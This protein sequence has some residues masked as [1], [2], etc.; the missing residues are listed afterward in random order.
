YMVGEHGGAAFV[1]I[2]IL[3]TLLI[4]LPIF[5]A[6]VMIGRRSHTNARDA[7]ARLSRHHPF[8]KAA[9]YLTI[10][11][12]V[13]IDCYYSVIG[14]W[15]LDYFLK[16]C[17]MTFVNTP[18]GEVSGLFETF[19]SSTW[20]PVVMHLVFLGACAAVVAGGV[21]SGIEKFSKVSLPVLFVLIV[22]ILIYSVTLPGAGDGVRYLLKPDWSELTPRTFAY[23][24]GQSFFSLSLGMG[25]IITYGSYVSKK[26]NILVT[27]TGTAVSDLLFALLAGF[28]IMPAVFAAG[29]APG[30]GPGLIFQSIPYVFSQMGAQLPVL[31]GIVSIVFFLTIIV[32][33]MTSCISLLEVG[34]SFLMERA[35]VSRLK[36]CLILFGICGSVGVLCS[37]SF[38][39]LNGV[40]IAGMTI[41]DFFD[42][43][44][45][46][47]LLLVM[48][49][50]SVV[51]V[52]WVLPRRVVHDEFTSRM[53]YPVNDRVFPVVW[54]L[55]R[56]VAPVAV[57]IIFLTNFML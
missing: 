23:A 10:V 54:F 12:P 53:R 48:A 29:I 51:F 21:K 19:V 7:F 31:S 57:V 20:T 13:L 9:G 3:A 55:I 45:S 27:S 46:N 43:A 17:A 44:C 39:P 41:F 5:L 24:M 36:A 40:R 37:L 56:W 16:S 8:W 32:A 26:E 38:G 42:W 33:A 6:E 35:G 34:V 47:I 28:A 50:L 18:P 1:I 15:S 4:S 14:G 2:Y 11:I 30:A 49:L 22:L 25:A 52:G